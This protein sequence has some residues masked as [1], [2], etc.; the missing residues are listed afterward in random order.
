MPKKDC[1][2]DVLPRP[3]HQCCS[4]EFF[5]EFVTLFGDNMAEH[6][7]V[8]PNDWV[9]LHVFR[10]GATSRVSLMTAR[11]GDDCICCCQD[12]ENCPPNDTQPLLEPG[13]DK[14]KRSKGIVNETSN[15]GSRSDSYYKNTFSTAAST[16]N[17]T[18]DDDGGVQPCTDCGNDQDPVGCN[19]SISGTP[20]ADN[21]CRKGCCSAYYEQSMTEGASPIIFAYKYSG[22]NLIWF[23]KEFAFNHN[24]YVSQC[25]GWLTQMNPFQGNGGLIQSSCQPWTEQALSRGCNANTCLPE[26]FGPDAGYDAPYLPCGC[27]PFPHINGGIYDS[28]FNRVNVSI[29]ENQLGYVANMTA[30]HLPMTPSEK[31]CCWCAN[32][33]AATGFEQFLKNRKEVY[34]NTWPFVDQIGRRAYGEGYSTGYPG[35]DCREQSSTLP[36]LNRDY[37]RPCFARGISPYLLRNSAKNYKMAFDIWGHGLNDDSRYFFG[38]SYEAITVN[39]NR[40]TK[41]IE[42]PFKKI[43]NKKNRLRDQF[44]GI[45]HLEHNFECFAYRSEDGSS[46]IEMQAVQN[47][48]NV[49]VPGFE[50]YGGKLTGSGSGCY[51]W[52]PWRYDSLK[53]Q[54]RRGVPRRV[55][56]VGSGVPLFHFDLARME[57]ISEE[58]NITG[59][60]GTFDGKEFL[61]H[62]YRYYYSLVYFNS[63][64]CQEP[65]DIPGPP[66]WDFS[67]LLNSYEY[68][69][70]WIK[71]MI[72]H[73]VIRIKDHAIDIAEEVNELISQGTYDQE[74]ELIISD[75]IAEEVGGIQE[76]KSILNLFG[77]SA[78][79][80][81]ANIKP[82]DVKN[83]LLNTSGIPSYSGADGSITTMNAFLPRR[84]ILPS[85]DGL[86]GVTG[87]A[88]TS[89]DWISYQGSTIFGFTGAEYSDIQISNIPYFLNITDPDNIFNQVLSHSKI[90]CGL[91]ANFLIDASGKITAFGAIVDPSEPF[92]TPAPIQFPEAIGCVPEYFRITNL[93]SWDGENDGEQFPFDPELQELANLE[94]KEPS[95]IQDGRV[96]DLA[97]KGKNFVVALADFDFGGIGRPCNTSESN[98]PDNNPAE[99]IY[100]NPNINGEN[101]EYEGGPCNE[102]EPFT[103]LVQSGTQVVFRPNESRP[104]NAYRLKSWGSKAKDY[105]TFSLSEGQQ[106]WIDEVVTGYPGRSIEG[107]RRRY[108][109]TNAWFIWTNAASG[110][111]HFAALDDFGGV[112]I[113]PN[114]DNTYEQSTK[115][116][117]AEDLD[118][119][120][121]SSDLR[122]GSLHVGFGTDFNYFP[123]IPRP[124]YVKE[125]EWNQQFYND[126]TLKNSCYKKFTCACHYGSDCARGTPGFDSGCA[127]CAE[128]IFTGTNCDESPSPPLYDK[129]CTLMGKLVRYGDQ[130]N[131]NLEPIDN[132]GRPRYT[133]LDCGHYNTLLLTNENKLEI[134][135]KFVKIDDKGDL[136]PNQP[137]ID[138]FIPSE[139]LQYAG[140]WSVQYACNQINC[141]GVIHSPILDASYNPP[142]QANVIKEIKSSA[143]YCVAITNNN[144]VHI[145][146]DK[147]MIPNEFNSESYSIGQTGY[148]TINLGD[149]VSI[150]SV[151][152]GVHAFYIG[153]KVRVGS[154]TA[155]RVYSYTRYNLDIG[156]KFPEHLQSSKIVSVGAGY[157]HGMAIFS[158][159]NRSLGWDPRAFANMNRADV[160]EDTLKYQFKDF[161]QLPLYFRRQAFFHAVNGYWDYSK[162]LYGGIGCMSFTNPQVPYTQ[163][164]NCSALAYNPYLPPDDPMYFDEDAS[165]SGFPKYFWMRADWRRSTIQSLSQ[166]IDNGG[167]ESNDPD[168][169]KPDTGVSIQGAGGNFGTIS[170]NYGS[171]LNRIGP[172]WGYGRP[173]AQLH[174]RVIRTP[175][176]S[177]CYRIPCTSPPKYMFVNRTIAN[178]VPYLRFG[179][180]I[181]PVNAYRSTKD[182]FQLLWSLFDSRRLGDCPGLVQQFWSY[183]KYAERHYYYGYDESDGAW[184][185]YD[186]PD[187]LGNINPLVQQFPCPINPPGITLDGQQ[188]SGGGNWCN[189]DCNPCGFGGSISFS[190]GSGYTGSG[191]T[192]TALQNYPRTGPN[193]ARESAVELPTWLITTRNTQAVQQTVCEII[194]QYNPSNPEYSCNFCFGSQPANNAALSYGGPGA[195]FWWGKRCNGIVNYYTDAENTNLR[196]SYKPENNMY[197]AYVYNRTIRTTLSGKDLLWGVSDG[198]SQDLD[199]RQ[200]PNYLQNRRTFND[201]LKDSRYTQ[202]VRP[203]LYSNSFKWIP[204]CWKSSFRLPYAEGSVITLPTLY[205]FNTENNILQQNPVETAEDFSYNMTPATRTAADIRCTEYIVEE[206]PQFIV[207]LSDTSV[208]YTILDG[209][210]NFTITCSFSH[211]NNTT[212]FYAEMYKLMPNGQEIFLQQSD[213]SETVPPV[214]LTVNG[215]G[216]DPMNDNFSSLRW[217]AEFSID[218]GGNISFNAG[219]KILFKLYARYKNC[220]PDDPNQTVIHFNRSS[221]G[222]IRT[223]MSYTRYDPLSNTSNHICFGPADTSVSNCV[224][225]NPNAVTYK[226]IIDPVTGSI[227]HDIGTAP[228]VPALFAC[229]GE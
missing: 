88:E 1:C 181:P 69:T 74:N 115:G 211:E 13:T 23:P 67:H 142:P 95:L 26:C 164:D 153:Y 48:C 227:F 206:L 86:P 55:M 215:N 24:P 214:G 138:A 6:S 169:C 165:R 73:K 132:D 228:V 178:D 30:F 59:V 140:S 5:T 31:S 223:G 144:V 51:R 79:S 175:F 85:F 25:T 159:T 36:G 151:S 229:C 192:G 100:S 226:K 152:L 14:E 201:V 205:Y 60:G 154:S 46:T 195:F 156:T 50:S 210:Y 167:G 39:I 2:C 110:M 52:T 112:F 97:F 150:D 187:F 54:M 146:G 216:T 34:L 217:N 188:P 176:G 32:A 84:A 171:C 218:L 71:E 9:A 225:D 16:S 196:D 158:N 162:W 133:N 37:K 81:N 129:T 20:Q 29:K 7:V 91:G 139:L 203:W 33:G 145:W 207:E 121:E 141:N 58:K 114:C 76:Y 221:S 122:Y 10:P 180:D 93:F 102:Y 44:I 135:G 189:I 157:I 68:V 89:S 170:S 47:H 197:R 126:I 56:Y 224:G 8:S 202:T 101:L 128:R 220:S 12:I 42:I 199:P 4:S 78:G 105:G 127:N 27:V 193:Y 62:Y 61:S 118:N 57:K 119:P 200:D 17:E 49:I 109:G 209:A 186:N 63:G 179:R 83:K 173:M 70:S 38:P 43:Y 99:E 124:G 123:H 40:L 194:D 172:V 161:A 219:E 21:R 148:S 19:Q 163:V 77:V 41:D 92:C 212:R 143:D 183:F 184:K 131:S 106:L 87:W 45:I 208:D 107:Q 111:Q 190:G 72:I 103:G 120:T 64:T 191:Y 137:V 28:V 66:E 222:L 75:E 130:G 94:P 98:T 65:G 136:I 116:L 117:G 174:R 134:Y 125:T 177:E 82:I 185:I 204:L 160:S 90:V 147:A 213:Y 113:P 149:V 11:P 104:G 3:D 155:S 15:L 168:K 182:V 18:V 198:L 166:V 53:W 35:S 96:I 80:S 108:P 22:C